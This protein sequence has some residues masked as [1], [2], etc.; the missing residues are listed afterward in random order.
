LVTL[1][2]DTNIIEWFNNPFSDPKKNKASDILQSICDGKHIGILI[3]PVV[4]EVYYRISITDNE[5]YAKAFI[6]S[7]LSMPNIIAIDITKDIGMFAGELYYK[8]HV[9]PKRTNPS[10]TKIPGAVDCLVAATNQY[11]ND[12]LVCT[13]DGDIQNMS[14]IQSDFFNIPT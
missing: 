1:I 2:L 7:L 10:L 14:E 12:S 11:I 6:N 9:L 8:Y 4:L 3:P 5:Q 13:D